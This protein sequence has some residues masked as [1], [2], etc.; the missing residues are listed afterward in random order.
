MIELRL[1][2][3]ALVIVASVY[4]GYN[5]SDMSWQAKYD[6]LEKEK[7]ELQ[8]QAKDVTIKEVIKYV[9]RV[10][11]VKV[12]GATIYEKVPVYITTK[13][14]AACVVPVSVARLL[15]A[16][17]T[18]TSLPDTTGNPDALSTATDTATGVKGQ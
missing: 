14:D 12:K 11:E 4:V 8:S 15:N 10:K 3:G 7:L 5:Y 13:A 16:A 9:D 2:A 1:I 18:S 6:K 17:A